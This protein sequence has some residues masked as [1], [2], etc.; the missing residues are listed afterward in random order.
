MEEGNKHQATHKVTVRYI[1]MEYKQGDNELNNIST[2]HCSS[3]VLRCPKV[4]VRNVEN[5]MPV[6]APVMW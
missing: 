1:I 2:Q 3:S 5:S 6:A 4:N